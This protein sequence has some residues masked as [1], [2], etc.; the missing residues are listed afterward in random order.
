MLPIHGV[1]PFLFMLCIISHAVASS[2]VSGS[3]AMLCSFSLRILAKL[4]GEN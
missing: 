3:I 2:G 4:S 1:R